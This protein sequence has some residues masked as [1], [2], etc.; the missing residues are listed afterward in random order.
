M[1]YKQKK[2][3]KMDIPILFITRSLRMISFGGMALVLISYLNDKIMNGDTHSVGKIIFFATAGDLFISLPL[4]TKADT[5]FGRRRTLMVGALL[6]FFAGITLL[7]TTNPLLIGFAL[8]IGVITT[9]GGEIGPFLPVEQ[10]CLTESMSEEQKNAAGFAS[11]FSKHNF[12]ASLSVSAG[13]LWTGFLL[14]HVVQ[15]DVTIVF[16]QYCVLSGIMFCLYLCLSNKVEP[17]VVIVGNNQHHHHKNTKGTVIPSTK[18]TT[19]ATTIEL[20]KTATTTTKTNDEETQNNSNKTE[21]EI[22]LKEEQQ[23]QQL[24]SQPGPITSF[25]LK[26]TGLTTPSSLKTISMLCALFA[27]DAF[28][29]G[30]IAQSIIV[31]WFQKRFDY[32]VDQLGA[33]LAAVNIIAGVTSLVVGKLVDRFGAINVMVFSHLPSNILLLFI[34][35]IPDGTMAIIVLLA[36]FSISQMDVPAR[37]AFVAAAVKPEE[38][39]ASGGL[40]NVAR[41]VGVLLSPLLW[42]PWMAQAIDSPQFKLPFIVAG[43]LKCVY[44]LILFA[45]FHA[46]KK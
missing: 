38:K 30:L 1:K 9:T 37:Q 32:S 5:V 43:G 39:S 25:I 28:A 11:L 6:K 16:I 2:L 14:D 7:L 18:T 15:N 21:E 33:M 41:S 10:A 20:T 12:V 24:E 23:Q 34:P 3:A 4:T 29:G 44:D 13:A 36:R 42:A 40:T 35:F 22:P 19:T 46:Y 8:C 17:D 45:L 26:L 31:V 27:V